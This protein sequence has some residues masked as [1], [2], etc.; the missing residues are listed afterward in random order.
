[1][2]GRNLPRGKWTRRNSCARACL[3]QCAEIGRRHISRKATGFGSTSTAGLRSTSFRMRTHAKA[4]CP[5]RLAGI[6]PLSNRL[7]RV[8]SARRL[9]PS[10]STRSAHFPTGG[11]SRFEIAIWRGRSKKSASSSQPQIESRSAAVSADLA[12]P[13]E[14]DERALETALVRVPTAGEK[15]GGSEDRRQATPPAARY[16]PRIKWTCRKVFVLAQGASH[17]S[18]TGPVGNVR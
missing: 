9:S 1:M 7:T 15:R 18:R 6:R 16:L 17:Q 2:M 3:K 10:T 14:V 4:S 8:A 5:P 12:T 11:A 13:G